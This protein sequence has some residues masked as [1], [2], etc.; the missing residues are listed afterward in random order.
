MGTRFVE[1]VAVDVFQKHSLDQQVILEHGGNHTQSG[2][3]YEGV[4]KGTRVF[5]THS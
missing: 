3:T 2:T 5:K 1:A 4:V